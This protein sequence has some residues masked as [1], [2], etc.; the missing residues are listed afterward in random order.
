MCSANF[1]GEYMLKKVISEKKFKLQKKLANVLCFSHCTLHKETIERCFFFFFNFLSPL[2]RINYAHFRLCLFSISFTLSLL[3]LFSMPAT[4]R[5][6]PALCL[7][8]LPAIAFCCLRW[9]TFCFHCRSKRQYTDNPSSHTH[10][11]TRTCK[12]ES[13]MSSANTIN[14]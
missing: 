11:H 4:T 3:Q 9:H 13:A 5:V 6:V 1:L 7:R 14:I 12:K 8:H 10:T 2:G